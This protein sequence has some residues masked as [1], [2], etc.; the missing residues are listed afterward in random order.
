MEWPASEDITLFFLFWATRTI[1]KEVSKRLSKESHISWWW[2]RKRCESWWKRMGIPS[3][4][5]PL[6]NHTFLLYDI[7]ICTLPISDQM[8]SYVFHCEIIYLLFNLLTGMLVRAEDALRSAGSARHLTRDSYLCL[9]LF[10]SYKTFS[11]PFPSPGYWSG[12]FQF[13]VS[14]THRVSSSP[15][16]FWFYSFQSPC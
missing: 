15:S 11:F 12:L 14:P 4:T 9:H 6:L 5:P 3:L 10:P 8:K 1:H 2:L 7:F 16:F 13:C